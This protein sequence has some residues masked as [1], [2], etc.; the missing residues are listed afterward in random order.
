MRTNIVNDDPS[1]VDLANLE[2]KARKRDR[3]AAA[4]LEMYTGA[5]A[6]M[7]V[8]DLRIFFA[9]CDSQQL[10]VLKLKRVDLERFSRYLSEDRGNGP[11]SVAR[12]LSTV[13]GFYRLACADQRINRDPSV[14]LRRPTVR[15][16]P[17]RLFG[18]TYREMNMTIEVAQRRSPMEGA[19]IGLMAVLGLRVSEACNVQI[20][21]YDDVI[22]GYRV[23]HVMG[24]GGFPTSRP[25]S[26][27]LVGLLED[28]QGDRTEGPLILRRDGKQ[29]DRGTAYNRVKSIVKAS[30][31]SPNIHPHSYR[32]GAITGVFETGA[33]PIDA[34]IFGNHAQIKDTLHYDRN[35]R[36]FDRSPVLA[37]SAAIAQ[38][39]EHHVPTATSPTII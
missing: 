25:M 1:A 39:V 11:A 16:N 15:S 9:W 4:F 28:A 31:V 27:M 14:L 17:A 32:H 2:S 34:Q 10:K 19:L 12:R 38:A 7:Y 29:M 13:R 20:G 33:D 36:S 22:R 24:K 18:I 26:P 5:T 21:D 8:V 37:H 3:A 6:R 23:L 35:L 30:G